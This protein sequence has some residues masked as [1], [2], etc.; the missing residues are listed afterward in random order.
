MPTYI[1]LMNL[2]DQGIKNIKDA[3]KRIQ[4]GVKALEAMGGKLIA[5]YL[6]MGEYDYV[7]IAEAPSDEVVTTFMLGLGV[8]GNVRTTT[9]RAF[10][11]EQL[12]GIIGKLP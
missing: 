12:A 1:S 7:G 2:T 9:M 8:G 10:T 5:F 3:P 11:A 6:V 4:E